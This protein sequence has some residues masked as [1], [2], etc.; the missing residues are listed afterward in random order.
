MNSLFAQTNQEQFM[1]KKSRQTCVCLCFICVLQTCSLSDLVE[2][3][4]IVLILFGQANKVPKIAVF[5]VLCLIHHAQYKVSTVFC[6]LSFPLPGTGVVRCLYMQR[7]GQGFLY[8]SEEIWSV[9]RSSGHNNCHHQHCHHPNS[10][11][12]HPI[13]IA[14]NTLCW[15]T[16]WRPKQRGSSKKRVNKSGMFLFLTVK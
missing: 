14:G 13:H 6:T 11:H 3:V 16:H 7:S 12:H 10:L 4:L 5:S 15:S 2:L 9:Q 8:P 1:Q